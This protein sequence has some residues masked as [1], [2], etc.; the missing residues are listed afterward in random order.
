MISGDLFGAGLVIV[1]GHQVHGVDIL[2]NLCHLGMLDEIALSADGNGKKESSVKALL[3]PVEAVAQLAQQH[4]V[5][6]LVLG[7]KAMARPGHPWILPVDVESIELILVDE[8]D[9]AL[10]E[11]AA[12]LGVQSR[13]GES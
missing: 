7:A 10:N 11:E 6:L 3:F 5:V 4:G 9:Y 1:V 2:L 13:I 8:F 12:T